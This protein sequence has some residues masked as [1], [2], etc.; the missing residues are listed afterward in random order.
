MRMELNFI[1]RC[2]LVTKG[3][4]T[5]FDPY[6]RPIF[7]E[8]LKPDVPCRV[9]QFNEEA[10]WDDFGFEYGV[11][12]VLFLGPDLVLD[13]TM[14]VRDIVDRVGRLVFPGLFLF[15]QIQPVFGRKGIHHYE[16]FL[17]KEGNEDG[18]K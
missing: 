4:Q 13:E 7:D 6:G 12:Y 16:V 3:Q 10:R 5:G 9:D 15:Q 11:S 17:K 18:E 8:R 14:K 1:H 2:T